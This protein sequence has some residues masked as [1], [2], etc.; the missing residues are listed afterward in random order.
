MAKTPTEIRS[1][2]RSHTDGALK[3]LVGIMN[4]SD[5]PEAARVAAANSVLDRGW[6]KAVQHIEAEVTR[7]YVARLP[8]KAESSDKWQ[9][10]NTPK[11]PTIQ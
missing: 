2:A 3:T 1:L 10:Q 7:R 8:N 11:Q 6:G 5:A 4:K 9:K